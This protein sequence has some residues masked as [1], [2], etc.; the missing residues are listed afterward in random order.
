MILYIIFAEIFL[1]NIREKNGI[2]GI[3][4]G[5]KEL[6]TSNFAYDTTIYIGSNSSLAHLET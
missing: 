2:K 4:L 5:E 1:E 6:E 3:V